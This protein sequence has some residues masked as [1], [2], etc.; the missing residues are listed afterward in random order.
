[1]DV[2]EIYLIEFQV[3]KIVWYFLTLKLAYFFM[4]VYM[5]RSDK[6]TYVPPVQICRSDT[7]KMYRLKKLFCLLSKKN[8]KN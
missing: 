6:G 5:C 2:F 8:E 7:V 1:M 4:L 3:S